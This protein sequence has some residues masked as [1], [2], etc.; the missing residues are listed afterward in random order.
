MSYKFTLAVKVTLNLSIR[1]FEVVQETGSRWLS[2]A[3]W[4]GFGGRIFNMAANLCNSPTMHSDNHL[5][6]VFRAISKWRIILISSRKTPPVVWF[7]SVNTYEW[8]TVSQ[9]FIAD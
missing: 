7:D 3:L 1:P 5:D 6:P 9:S 8:S 2:S 4:D